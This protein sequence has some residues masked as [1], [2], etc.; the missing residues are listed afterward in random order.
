MKTLGRPAAKNRN[1]TFL[2]LISFLLFGN[3][4]CMSLRKALREHFRWVFGQPPSS[5]RYSFCFFLLLRPWP[6]THLFPWAKS[7]R[8]PWAKHT[9]SKNALST[10]R[11]RKGGPYPYF[12]VHGPQSKAQTWRIREKMTSIFLRRNAHFQKIRFHHLERAKGSPIPLFWAFRGR[13]SKAHV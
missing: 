6:V 2:Q 1:S 5:S 7:A 10:L 8:F 12:G 4:N 9:F 3:E 13:Q 11:A